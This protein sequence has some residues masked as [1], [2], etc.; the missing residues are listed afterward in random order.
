MH[1]TLSNNSYVWSACCIAELDR[2]HE[3]RLI[4][5]PPCEMD[6]CG[7][8]QFTDKGTEAPQ[9]YS[10]EIIASSLNFHF[11][12]GVIKNYSKKQKRISANSS[13]FSGTERSSKNCYGEICYHWL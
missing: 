5:D 10:P 3:Y 7:Y 8:F 9:R 13:A 12:L 6:I 11:Y 4:C 2:S 1:V